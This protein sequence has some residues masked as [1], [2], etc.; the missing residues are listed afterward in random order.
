MVALLPVRFGRVEWLSRIRSTRSRNWR[1][2]A[3]TT[4]VASPSIAVD[5]LE[6]LEEAAI[7]DRARFLSWGGKGADA[8]GGTDRR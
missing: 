3:S 6:T 4:P 7:E 5:C 1:I 8:G 2:A